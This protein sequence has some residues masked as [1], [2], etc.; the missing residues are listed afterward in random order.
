MKTTLNVAG[1]GKRTSR[2]ALGA[3]LAL[4]LGILTLSP[5]WG[6]N[7]TEPGG[8]VP[9]ACVARYVT[10]SYTTANAWQAKDVC[11][12][13]EVAIASGGQCP[14]G[15]SM[16]GN[17]LSSPPT[18]E[19]DRKAHILCSGTGTNAVWMATCCQ[20]LAREEL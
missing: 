6:L 19:F 15:T 20:M 5:T 17:D 16:R 4:S 10:G 14:T 12:S 18:L 1:V 3:A 9:Y 7:D 2:A 11:A 8:D 13:D